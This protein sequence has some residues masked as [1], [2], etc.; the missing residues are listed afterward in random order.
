MRSDREIEVRTETI[1]GRKVKF[2]V[3]SQSG[4]FKAECDGDEYT[5]ATLDDAR[6]SVVAALRRNRVRIAL[7]ATMLGVELSEH[8]FHRSTNRSSSTGFRHLTITGIHSRSGNTLVRWDD[9]GDTEQIRLYRSHDLVRRLSKSE[10]QEYKELAT[11]KVKASEALDA[12][13]EARKLS[14]KQD[15][16]DYIK[17]KIQEK[18]DEPKDEPAE[19]TEDPRVLGTGTD[20]KASRGRK[21]GR[22]G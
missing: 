11:A 10:E 18:I 22:K 20:G 16:D 4:Q 6:R 19:E 21:K 3:G 9:T 14:G 1:D 7:P 8:P 13:I 17:E 12:F 5:G 2:T 15:L